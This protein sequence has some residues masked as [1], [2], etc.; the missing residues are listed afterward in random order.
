MDHTRDSSSV[1][2]IMKLIED[3]IQEQE[4]SQD[5]Q[6]SEDLM[7]LIRAAQQLSRESR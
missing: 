1:L 4:N 6:S 7:E 2:R 5:R 3:G